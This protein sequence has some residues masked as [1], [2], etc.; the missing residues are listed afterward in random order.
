MKKYNFK[1]EEVSVEL[2]K[3]ANGRNAIVLKDKDNM[4]YA[5]ATI[6]VPNE[7]LPDS[8]VVIKNYSENE[9][10]LDFL[11]E[12]ELVMYTYRDCILSH[13]TKAPICLLN[14]ELLWSKS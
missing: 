4:P 11:T 10:M 13:G 12:N 1:G 6:N 5:T 7:D 3:Y 14:Y 2:T 9:G 8:F